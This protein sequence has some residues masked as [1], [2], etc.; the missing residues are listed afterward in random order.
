MSRRAPKSPEAL[1]SDSYPE[2]EFELGSS[3]SSGGLAQLLP[4]LLRR[5][6][7]IVLGAILGVLGGL[8]YLSKAPEVYSARATLLVKQGSSSIMAS[9]QADSID[10]KSGEA[11]NTLTQQ[12]TRLEFLI[13][14]ARRPDV[15]KLENLIPPATDW[16]PD[17]AAAWLGS[18]PSGEAAASGP[19]TIDPVALGSRIATWTTVSIRK[20]T[21]L[22]DIV[23]EHPSPEASQVLADAIAKEFV[24]EISRNR[25]EGQDSSTLILTA[26]SEEARQVLQREQKTLANYTQALEALRQLEEKEARFAEVSLRY[27]S[28]HPDFI[29]A[30][31]SLDDSQ[32]RFL[33]KFNDA[34]TARVDAKYWQEN[35]A[36]LDDNTEITDQARLQVAKR[37]LSARATVL[38]S[39]I[40]S[41][42][43]LFKALLE[44]LAALDV[45]K[46]AIEGGVELNSA[47]RLPQLPSSPQPGKVVGAGLVLGLG[48]GFAL[49]FLLVKLDTRIHTVDQAEL[50]T[51]LPV[52]ATIRKL[53]LKI[54]RKVAREKGA[55][56]GDDPPAVQKWDRRL[57]FRKGLIDS[58]NAES[59]RILRASVSLLGDEKK[60]SVTLFTS[61]LPGEGKTL[62]SANFALAAAQQGKK[63]LL[64]DLDLRKPAVHKAFGLKRSELPAGVTEILAGRVA[65]KDALEKDNGQE[66]LF[67]LYAG[68]K[69]PNPGSL[70]SFDGISEL[71][72]D[73]R[74]SFEVIVIDSAP[75]LAVS[76]TRLIV[77]AV[78]NFC[79]VI[80]AEQTPKA[81][82]RKA[83]N[84]L[85][86]DGTPPDGVV[87]NGFEE[88]TGLFTKKYGYGQYGKGYGYGSYGTYGADDDDD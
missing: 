10:Y 21:R 1:E 29:K 9:R 77:P 63:T 19:Q 4:D 87:V 39:E 67:S 75:L 61:A 12:I 48:S 27:L 81:A 37:L 82:I 70:L 32:K 22:L 83:L 62:T 13:E 16:T 30:K 36:E 72:A 38:Q 20:E 46:G 15:Q 76:D 56:P 35:R 59:F 17:W 80:R 18:E 51:S 43:S 3:S 28:K 40:E 23:V 2:E 26:K 66:N 71:L 6:H 25:A 54:L 31:A 49:A 68:A 47:A 73:L 7:W 45:N 8:Y 34:R 53:D 60:R 55:D 44:Q 5:W 50:L 58:V 14:V 78:D 57:V 85:Q 41:Q 86:D 74:K 79:L 42:D 88:K 84:L 11:L 52:L 24:E 69:A 33:E 64:I 65:W